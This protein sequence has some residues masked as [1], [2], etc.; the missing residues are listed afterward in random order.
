MGNAE[1]VRQ[2]H[3]GQDNHW[4]GQARLIAPFEGLSLLLQD[5]VHG[6]ARAQVLAFV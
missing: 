4:R 1:P 6:A 2:N 3:S 5:A